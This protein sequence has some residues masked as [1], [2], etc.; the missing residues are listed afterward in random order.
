MHAGGL[1]ALYW[2]PPI[3][4][5]YLKVGLIDLPVYTGRGTRFVVVRVRNVHVDLLT[6]PDQ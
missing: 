6:G 1:S 3:S 2:K 5:P 4:N